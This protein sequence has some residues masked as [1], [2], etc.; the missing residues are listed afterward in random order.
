VDDPVHGSDGEQAREYA[1]RGAAG[2]GALEVATA[3]RYGFAAGG[4]HQQVSA[5]RDAVLPAGESFAITRAIMGGAVPGRSAA[6]LRRRQAR[7]VPGRGLRG[8]RRNRP[9]AGHPRDLEEDRKARRAERIRAYCAER[10]L[11]F[12]RS[13][14]SDDHFVIGGERLGTAEVAARYLPDLFTT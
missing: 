1:R 2:H 12:A 4:T 5:L 10:G 8:T 3:G 9:T 14:H 6:D 7:G 11:S 13:E